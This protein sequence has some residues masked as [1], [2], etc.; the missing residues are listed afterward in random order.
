LP[1][2]SSWESLK[3]E[4]LNLLE[5]SLK[6]D[7][8]TYLPI[9]NDGTRAFISQYGELLHIARYLDGHYKTALS[10]GRPRVAQFLHQSASRAHTGFGLRFRDSQ[11]IVK[12]KLSWINDRWPRITYTINDVQISVHFVVLDGILWHQ[13]IITNNTNEDQSLDLILDLGLIMTEVFEPLNQHGSSSGMSEVFPQLSPDLKFDQSGYAGSVS[14]VSLRELENPSKLEAL[15]RM[16]LNHEPATLRSK[17]CPV[18]VNNSDDY[19]EFEA[20]SDSETEQGMGSISRI[21]GTVDNVHEVRNRT[22]TVLKGQSQELLLGW[23]IQQRPKEEHEQTLFSYFDL[24]SYLRQETGPHW[25]FQEP[26]SFMGTFR[27][28]LQH[29]LCVSSV[30]MAQS[31]ENAI[32]FMNEDVNFGLSTPINQLYVQV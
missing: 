21:G 9:G 30:P 31:S 11:P 28:H 7:A 8:T 15:F 17:S 5:L 14:H 24:S 25:R 10:I 19:S 6:T 18:A 12:P 1:Q 13:Y 2:V 4:D 32:M 22:F 20:S 26:K 16:W 23:K 27:R 3:K 29:I